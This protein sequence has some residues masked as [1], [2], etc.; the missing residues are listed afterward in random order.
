MTCV[1]INIKICSDAR[2]VQ[3]SK[4]TSETRVPY[5]ITLT[6]L[7]GQIQ[8]RLDPACNLA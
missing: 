7:P 3:T 8:I 6:L 1:P 2:S 5:L 4:Y